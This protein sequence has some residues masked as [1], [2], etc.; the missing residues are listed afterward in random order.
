MTSTS[1][2]SGISGSQ[3][4]ITAGPYT[5]IITEQGAG[6]RALDRDGVPLILSYDADELAPAAF[7]QL[8]TPWPNRIDRG[9]Y[10]YGGGDYELDITERERDTAIHGLLRWVPWAVVERE[11]HRLVLGHR[12]LGT[13]GYPFRLDLTAEYALTADAGLAV[14]MSAHN[15]GTRPAPYGHG[16]HPYLT[17]G[18]P[19]DECTAVL[20][21]GRHLPVDAREIPTGPPEDVAGTPYDFREP[22]LLGDTRLNTAFTGL[23]RGA[24]GL[25]WAR[26]SYGDRTVALWADESFPWLE[27]YTGDDVPGGGRRMGLAV[28]PMTCPPNAFASGDDVIDL[29]PG[30]TTTGSWGIVFP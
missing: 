21:A 12:L 29:K 19:I 30:H 2:I 15:T 5:A 22:R 4:E 25:T 20:P 6:L 7:G 17:A 18:R 16:A 23:T 8:L 14:R 1:G 9:R 10:A 11:P 27:V 24:D 26:L 28:E 3:Y 13:P